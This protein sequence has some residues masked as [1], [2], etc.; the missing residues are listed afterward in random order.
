MLREFNKVQD[1][2]EAK[3]AEKEY[4]V[5]KIVDEKLMYKRPHFLVKWRNYHSG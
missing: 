1:E 2:R 5:E 4:E 3:Q